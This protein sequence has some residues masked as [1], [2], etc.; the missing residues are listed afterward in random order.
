MKH[1]NL[2]RTHR[3]LYRVILVKATFS[4]LI[5]LGLLFFPAQFFGSQGYAALGEV[6]PSLIWGV[7]WLG[8]ALVTIA[9]LVKMPYAY[10]RVGLTGLAAVYMTWAIGI[11][12]NQVLN[13]SPYS[14]LAVFVYMSASLVCTFLV[15]EPPINPATAAKDGEGEL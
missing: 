2:H 3:L 4:A 12:V 15:M 13:I 14:L 11:L 5:G 1:I 8:L 6:F 7:I 9:G 10:V